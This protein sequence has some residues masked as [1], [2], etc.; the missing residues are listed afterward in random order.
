MNEWSLHPFLDRL[1]SGAPSPGGGA[2]GALAA[3]SAASLIE[4]VCH[5]TEGRDAYREYQQDVAAAI[6]QASTLRSTL[7]TQIDGDAAAYDQVAAAYAMPRTSREERTSRR[8]AID[9]ALAEAALP[10]LAVAQAA[11]DLLH[12]ARSLIGKTNTN[13]VGDLGAAAALAEA[14]TQIAMLNVLENVKG[15]RGEATS[16]ALRQRLEQ[17][18]SGSHEL[19]GSIRQLVQTMVTEPAS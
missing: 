1:A 15:M 18:T 14:A 13:L 8:S 19:A 17:A 7:Q 2:A 11:N 6:T 4:M 5:Y 3:A 12:L 10:P 16:L 9:S